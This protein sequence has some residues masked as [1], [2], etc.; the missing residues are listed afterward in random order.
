MSER[1]GFPQLWHRTP[2]GEVIA[3]P[4]LALT[5][6]LD[7]TD[8]AHVQA[9]Y[10]RA[11]ALVGPQLTHYWAERM[12]QPAKITARALGMLPTW[13]RKPAEAH[14]YA[15]RFW[16]GEPL[17]VS[18]WSVEIF[19]TDIPYD[20]ARR[21][22][23]GPFLADRERRLAG[24]EEW[25]PSTV[26]RVTVPVDADEARPEVWVPWVLGFDILKDGWF[27]TAESGFS[28]TTRGGISDDNF[29][30]AACSRY[31]GLDWFSARHSQ[32][33]CRYEPSLDVGLFQVKRA[34]WLTFV[35]EVAVRLLGGA[36]A[37]RAQLAEDPA[38]RTHPL[39]HGLCIQAGDRPELG[40]LSRHEV[41]EHV[42]RVAKAIRP[43]RLKS[44]PLAF[45]EAFV[46]HWFNMFDRD[47]AQDAK[48]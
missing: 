43:V 12:R 3:C 14:E 34:A 24:R 38:I 19:Y 41:P 44:I 4:T 7:E 48:P 25:F 1:M 26:L 37:V 11:M 47:P 36:D 27:V 31:P 45:E 30:R 21:A 13:L 2:D 20:A 8:H 9:F 10:D 6:H 16:G 18:P 15:I 35:H 29:M 39:A 33:L 42:R 22:R 28:M 5:V 40:D 32:F 46:D 23:L 17:D